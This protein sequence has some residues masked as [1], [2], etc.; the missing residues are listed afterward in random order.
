MVKRFS[1]ASDGVPEVRTVEDATARVA[2]LEVEL[3]AVETEFG[4]LRD[5]ANDFEIKFSCPPKHTTLN[6]SRIKLVCFSFV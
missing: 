1:V 2:Q 6:H 4:P 5:A 3:E